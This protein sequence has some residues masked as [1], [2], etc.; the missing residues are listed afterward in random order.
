MDFVS[1]LMVGFSLRTF[2]MYSSILL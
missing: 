1:R 2:F